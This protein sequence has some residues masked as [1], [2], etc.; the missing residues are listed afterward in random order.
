MCRQVWDPDQL[1]I[2][3]D[4]RHACHHDCSPQDRTHGP[5][6]SFCIASKRSL[7]ALEHL[8]TTGDQG[9]ERAHGLVSW[10]T[11]SHQVVHLVKE[12]HL[13]DLVLH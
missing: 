1:A 12:V 13:V 11:C 6:V 5:S 10:L 4:E 3:Y 2:V 7:V 8:T 9:A